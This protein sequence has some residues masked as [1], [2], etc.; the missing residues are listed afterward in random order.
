MHLDLFAVFY[1]HQKPR[2]GQKTKKNYFEILQR[3]IVRQL[4]CIQAYSGYFHQ[5]PRYD[6]KTRNIFEILQR[7]IPRYGQKTK[8]IFLKFNN[9]ALCN[10][11]NRCNWAYSE[12]FIFIRSRDIAKKRKNILNFTT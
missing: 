5:K 8:K 9:I 12:P 7:S 6:Q 1:F 4:K 10:I 3:S 2:Y 11:Q